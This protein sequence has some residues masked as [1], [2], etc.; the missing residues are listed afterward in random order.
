[1]AN[2]ETKELLQ[3]LLAGLYS[4]ESADEIPISERQGQ[5]YLVAG[6]KQFLGRI[7]NSNTQAESIFNKY[8]T[9]GSRFS[10]TSIF[11]KYCPYGGEYGQWS[12]ENPYCNTPPKLFING[13]FLGHISSNR[14]VQQKIPYDGFLYALNNNLN[15]LLKGNVIKSEEDAR[16]AIGE[17]YLVAADGAFLGKLT[18]NT[19]D[20]QS[21]FSVFGPYGSKFSQTSIFNDFSKYGGTFSQMSPFNK[22]SK[23][24]PKLY[25]RG[26]HVGY[27]TINTFISNRVD[28]HNLKDWVTKNIGS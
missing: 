5:S 15:D 13:Q 27:L 19:F 4:Q 1:M 23:N 26:Q 16:Q 21:I 24:P 8:G 9:Y 3:N 20:S 10:P 6:N 28:P 18:L 25:I 11:N 14:Y 12:P 7:V 17:S 2:N 22:F